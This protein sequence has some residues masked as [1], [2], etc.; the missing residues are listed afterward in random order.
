LFLL[1]FEKLPF[2]ILTPILLLKVVKL[3]KPLQLF[4]ETLKFYK[5]LNSQLENRILVSFSDWSEFIKTQFIF[6]ILSAPK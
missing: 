1:N 3:G 5:K 6:K 2:K 4:L